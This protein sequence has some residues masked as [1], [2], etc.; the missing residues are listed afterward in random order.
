VSV[1]TAPFAA[2]WSAIAGA[3]LVVVP[4]VSVAA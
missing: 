2:D 1:L 3:P 4:G